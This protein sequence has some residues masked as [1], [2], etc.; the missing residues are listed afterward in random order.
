MVFQEKFSNTNPT[1]SY[2]RARNA[3]LYEMVLLNF[4]FGKA[5]IGCTH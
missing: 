2:S 5:K 3:W 4:A 1:I